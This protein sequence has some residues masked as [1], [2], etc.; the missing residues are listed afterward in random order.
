MTKWSWL[1]K[2]LLGECAALRGHLKIQFD[3]TTGKALRLSG[4]KMKTKKKKKLG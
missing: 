3:R 2:L 4:T 1:I